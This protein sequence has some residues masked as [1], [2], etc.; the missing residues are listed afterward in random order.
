[1]SLAMFA[2]AYLGILQEKLFML[3]GKHPEEM[4]LYVVILF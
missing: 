4:M 1:M 2:S 3:Y